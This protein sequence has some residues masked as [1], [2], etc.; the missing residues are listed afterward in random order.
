VFEVKTYH[1]AN[2]ITI[3]NVRLVVIVVVVTRGLPSFWEQFVIQLKWQILS[4][5]RFFQ[6]NL[7]H[8]YRHCTCNCW[9]FEQHFINSLHV[10]LCPAFIH[11]FPWPEWKEKILELERGST[12]S[13]SVENSLRKRLWTCRKTECVMKGE[14][15]IL[16]SLKW[17][18]VKKLLRRCLSRKSE[19]CT[20]TFR[21]LA[22]TDNVY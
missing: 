12:R 11:N 10:C 2:N 22:T 20:F 19:D 3:R 16:F 13:R 15:F 5:L 1:I 4:M 6:Y 7:A 9:P 17:R 8:L 18:D 21:G 14:N